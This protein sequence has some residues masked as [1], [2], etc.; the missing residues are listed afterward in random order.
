M[1]ERLYYPMTR[2]DGVIIVTQP[3]ENVGK[4]IPNF[5]SDGYASSKLG[6]GWHA[7]FKDED[8]FP[9]TKVTDHIFLVNQQSG[10]QICL[11]MAVATPT[12][13]KFIMFMSHYDMFATKEEGFAVWGCRLDGYALAWE[14][15]NAELDQWPE[16]NRYVFINDVFVQ[17]PMLASRMFHRAWEAEMKSV[18]PPTDVELAAALEGYTNLVH[19]TGN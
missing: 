4:G 19:D 16:E 5:S 11:R 9:D 12:P 18:T 13:R 6:N 8:A 15:I 2:Q 17:V 1:L 3:L 14:C 7:L 10:Q